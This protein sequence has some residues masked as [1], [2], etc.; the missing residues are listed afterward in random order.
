MNSSVDSISRHV[1]PPKQDRSRAS[2]ERVFDAAASLLEE[3]GYDDLTLLEVS[4]KSGVSIGSIY[5]RVKSKDDL[6]HAIQ[7]HVLAQLEVEVKSF[8]DP[9]Q[10]KGVE[11][12]SLIRYLIQEIGEFLRR[13]VAM[14][15]AL[16]A[17]SPQDPIL[18]ERGKKFYERISEGFKSLLLL[19]SAEIGHP[20]PKHAVHVCFNFPYACIQKY[21]GI[22]I[23]EDTN[24]GEGSWQELLDD[25]AVICTSY[26]QIK[27]PASATS[28]TG[29]ETVA[30]LPARRRRAAPRA[31]KR[32]KLEAEK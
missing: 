10:W 15:R 27:A 16:L 31:S 14:H 6:I 9:A 18:T 26:L 24:I 1:R 3:K 12:K 25:L 17:R 11:L 28:Q 22:G 21:L 29:T 19:H 13:H 7:Q 32:I 23:L 5:C 2:F 20:N 30:S 8:T 4:R